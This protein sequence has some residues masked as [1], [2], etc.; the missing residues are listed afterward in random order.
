[1]GN[2]YHSIYYRKKERSK[3]DNDDIGKPAGLLLHLCEGILSTGKV[4][5]LDSGFC[6]LQ[7]II[8]LKKRDVFASALIKKRR[9]WPKYVGLEGIAK[10]IKD[11]SV[12]T[13]MRLRGV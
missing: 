1:M 5:I 3:P 4:V 6:M 10:K 8:E 2:E 12:G 9:Y 7:G 11:K 13:T